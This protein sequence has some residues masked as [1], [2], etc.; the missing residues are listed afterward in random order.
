[1]E[2]NGTPQSVD[3]S[4]SGR[5]SEA[6]GSEVDESLARSRL[7][8]MR[9]DQSVATESNRPMYPPP[10]LDD[11]NHVTEH[12]SAS[13]IAVTGHQNMSRRPVLGRRRTP[14]RHP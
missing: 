10:G 1:M 9:M 6:Q 12:P 4:H 11:S 8:P 7:G 3:M 14:L 13:T 5:D 2:G